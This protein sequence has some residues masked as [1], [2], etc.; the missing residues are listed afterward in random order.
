MRH[1][2]Q[3]I[4]SIGVLKDLGFAS[5]A[6]EQKAG[7]DAVQALHDRGTLL[8][9]RALNSSTRPAQSYSGAAPEAFL[10]AQQPRTPRLPF[11]VDPHSHLSM[12]MQVWGGELSPLIQPLIDGSQQPLEWQADSVMRKRKKKMNKHKHRKRLRKNRRKS[13]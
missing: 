2:R 1:L 7:R 10:A 13:K 12:Q 3:L 4:R 5:T 6:A 9:A 8:T 11:V